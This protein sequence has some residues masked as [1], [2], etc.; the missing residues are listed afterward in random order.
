M[1]QNIDLLYKKNTNNFGLIIHEEGSK[2]FFLMNLKIS[3]SEC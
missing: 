3:W 1:I 2:D